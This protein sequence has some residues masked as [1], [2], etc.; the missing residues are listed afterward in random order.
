MRRWLLLLIVAALAAGCQPGAIHPRPGGTGGA[1]AA[2][3]PDTPLI[4]RDAGATGGSPM[5]TGAGGSGGAGG[6]V[7]AASSRP[8]D[9]ARDA[10][11]DVAPDA[12]TYRAP[13]SGELAIDELLVNP[14][15]DDL[16]REWIEIVS[17][18]AEALDLS[19][20]HLATATTDVAA[21][22]GVIAPGALRL[23]GQ[24]ADATKNGGLVVDA[25]YGTKLILINADGRL[26]ICVG[27]CASGVVIDAVS[28]GT[29]TDAFTGHAL[30]VD[31]ATKAI[32]PAQTPF[33]TAGSF[34]TPGA[35]NPA[36]AENDDG[37]S[38]DAG[39]SDAD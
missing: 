3:H 33:G 10:N 16:G 24:S 29:L 1:V 32:C 26:S 28:W 35:P 4:V 18:A 21:P 7:D 11:Q 39:V 27:P 19:A 30:I 9:A 17:H 34:G 15:G 8:V 31:P 22:G 25:A 20:L 14:T 12:P 23:L 5:R 2:D 36:C 13:Q 6:T 37:G 38:P